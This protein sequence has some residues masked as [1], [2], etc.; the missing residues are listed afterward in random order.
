MPSLP[1]VHCTTRFG[2]TVATIGIGLAA[3][4]GGTSGVAPFTG[5]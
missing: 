5:P 1:T 4:T 3:P 2:A